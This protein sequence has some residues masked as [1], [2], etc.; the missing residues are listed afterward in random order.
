MFAP[1]GLVAGSRTSFSQPRYRRSLPGT[2]IRPESQNH[3]L[4]LRLELRA[5]VLPAGKISRQASPYLGSVAV[6][7]VVTEQ[8]P[9]EVE[10][11]EYL[12]LRAANLGEL[13]F[14]LERSADL[15]IHPPAS[16]RRLRA[17]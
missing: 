3:I 13:L 11:N 12:D 9:V 15:V 2:I 4:H 8:V 17:A 14:L 7:P 5:D 1:P 16:Q 6:F 10:R